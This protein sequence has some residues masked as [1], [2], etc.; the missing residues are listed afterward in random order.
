MRAP[1]MT[2]FKMPLF[3]WTLYGTAWIQILATPILAVTLMLI[4]GERLLNIGFFDPSLGGDPILYQHLFWIYSH[5]AVYI[6]ILPAMGA[7][8][9]IIPTFSN[10]SIFGYK[11]IVISTLAI[12]FVG[13]FVWGHHM[14]TS[15]MSGTALYTFSILTFLVAIPSAIKVFNWVSTMHKASIQLD[16]PFFW[17][18]SFLFVFMIG[19]LSGLALGALSVNVHLHDTAF[20]VAHFHY[21]VFGGTGFAFMGAIHYWFPKMWG[22][23]YNTRMATTGWIFFFI[24]FNTLYLPMFFL[25]VAGMPRRYY[26]YVDRFHGPNIISTIGSWVL[27]TGLMIIIVNLIHAAKNGPVASKDPWGGKTLEWTVDSPPTFENFEEIPVVEKGP[28]DYR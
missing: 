19:G 27:F 7:I 10:K 25:G 22:R 5:P 26:D 24:G 12:A 20:V 14:F 28:Y 17:A 3:P 11:V 8:S 2:W 4:A 16:P 21:I 9:E 6:M 18:V 1:G 15:G 23:M 13:Y